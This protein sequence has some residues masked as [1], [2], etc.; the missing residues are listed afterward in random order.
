MLKRL[1]I[2]VLALSFIMAFTGT[3]FSEIYPQDDARTP[4]SSFDPS[5]PKF[6]SIESGN[7]V[8]AS[9]PV[10]NS[11]TPLPAGVSLPAPPLEYFCLDLTYDDG[12][13]LGYWTIDASGP[14][15]DD[16]FNVRYTSDE[17][18]D[19]TLMT[20]WV[21]IYGPAMVG[22]PDMMVYL[23]DDD[24][25]GNPGTALDSI[26]VPYASMPTVYTWMG[27][28]FYNSPNAPVGGWVFSD[29]DDYHYGLQARGTPGTDGIAML[30]ALG[31]EPATGRTIFW[32][33]V[34]GAWGTMLA[35]FGQDL[36]MVII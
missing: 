7:P 32:D 9:R 12:N 19:C 26:F 20:F 29:G 33:G 22:T 11:I 6:G 27:F 21:Q 3:A 1:L 34:A 15:T 10:G 35:V 8:P 28:D 17:N 5:N 16:L 30:V 18:F 25:F 24:G 36:M 4:A 23:W 31:A 2:A 14:G 13:V